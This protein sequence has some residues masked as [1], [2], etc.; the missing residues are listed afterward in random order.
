M[1]EQ[2]KD[3]PSIE[4]IKEQFRKAGMPVGEWSEE[5]ERKLNTPDAV[6]RLKEGSEKIRD[7]LQEQVKQDKAQLAVA[8][9]ELKRLEHGG[10]RGPQGGLK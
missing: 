4:D 6:H 9:E 3:Q 10:A 1:A 7:V 2:D 5:K 8:V